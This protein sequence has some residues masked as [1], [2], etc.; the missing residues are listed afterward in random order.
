MAKDDFAALWVDA[1]SR[2]AEL[3]GKDLKDALKGVP[4]PRTADEL[5][6]SV[7]SQN[8]KYDD[9]RE[10]RGGSEPMPRSLLSGLLAGFMAVCAFE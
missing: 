1:R 4:M 9:F 2:Y 3:S 5:W 10:K 7:D 6:T 8:K